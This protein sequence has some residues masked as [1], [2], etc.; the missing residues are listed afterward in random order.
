MCIWKTYLEI[1]QIQKKKISR[2]FATKK[3]ETA[4]DVT[5]EQNVL[6]KDLH[7]ERKKKRTLLA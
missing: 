6:F 4:C 1:S 3:T 7:G 2:N 5:N